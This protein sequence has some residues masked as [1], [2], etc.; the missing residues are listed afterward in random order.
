MGVTVHRRFWYING[1]TYIVYGL[2]SR[3]ADVV[4]THSQ[5][6]L[7]TSSFFCSA[8]FKLS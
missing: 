6:Y 4:Q 7:L 5:I 2:P 1:S 3:H 8:I